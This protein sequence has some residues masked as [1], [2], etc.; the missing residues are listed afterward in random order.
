MFRTFSLYTDVLYVFQCV[1]LHTIKGKLTIFIR[2]NPR[3]VDLPQKMTRLT[4]LYLADNQLEAVPFIPDAVRI[5]HLQVCIFEPKAQINTNTLHSEPSD[6][7]W[8][9]TLLYLIVLKLLR[10]LYDFFSSTS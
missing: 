4:N 1:C 7:S 2:L 8:A 10:D 9:Q 6:L 5:L 3:Y